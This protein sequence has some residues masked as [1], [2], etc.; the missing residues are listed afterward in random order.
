M[1]LS[2]E[3]IRRGVRDGR[4]GI[5]PYSETQVEAAHVNLHLGESD[6]MKDDV[7]TIKPRGF[8]LART[9]ERITL[10][11][12]LCGQLEGRSKL[13]QLG[14]SV[15]QSSTLVEPQSDTTMVL[16]IYNV[17]S[18]IVRLER[19]KK[20]AKLILMRITDDF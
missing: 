12:D 3:A 4:I 18:E 10:P 17:S 7:L 14:L 2:G 11:K 8:V 1:V 9:L 6:A 13:A 5:S 20:V 16:E 15:E 19:G